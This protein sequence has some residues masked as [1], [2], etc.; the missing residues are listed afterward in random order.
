MSGTRSKM[1]HP[2]WQ[3]R[4]HQCMGRSGRSVEHRPFSVNLPP[5]YIERIRKLS[6]ERRVLQKVILMEAL[7]QLFERIEPAAPGSRTI[8][9]PELATGR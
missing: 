4:D 6:V 8:G 9:F 5:E 7:D 3:S 2:D 1:L